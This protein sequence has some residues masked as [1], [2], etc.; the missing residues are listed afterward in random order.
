MLEQSKSNSNFQKIDNSDIF[1]IVSNL[2]PIFLLIFDRIDF[3]T[4][5]WIYFFQFAFLGFLKIIFIFGKK[6]RI[7]DSS[8]GTKFAI[9]YFLLAFYF[10][11]IFL[12]LISLIH[13]PLN[14]DLF[15]Y[16]FFIL[17]IVIFFTSHLYSFY[18]H[19]AKKY[20]L[21]EVFLKHFG[22]RLG[23]MYILLIIAANVTLSSDKNLNI[24]YFIIKTIIDIGTHKIEHSA[25]KT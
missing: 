3:W 8:P 21:D 16:L 6:D 25:K 12:F 4:G 24:F 1:L 5:I 22:L 11:F 14:L 9:A 15:G 7:K 20:T 23:P 10:F 2:I 19:K 13:R 17:S 18:F